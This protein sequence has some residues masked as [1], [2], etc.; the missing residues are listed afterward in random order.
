MAHEKPMFNTWDKLVC[1]SFMSKGKSPPYPQDPW[2]W[3]VNMKTHHIPWMWYNIKCLLSMQNNPQYPEYNKVELVGKRGG[4][5]IFTEVSQDCVHKLKLIFHML[6]RTCF[7]HLGITG[8]NLAHTWRE[9]CHRLHNREEEE[10]NERIR[11]LLF[12]CP[13]GKSFIRR[14]KNTF[15]SHLNHLAE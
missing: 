4:S 1:T 10:D 12:H 6:F 2:K 13:L 8:V 11:W 14:K 5:V 3:S 9:A 7:P 15:W